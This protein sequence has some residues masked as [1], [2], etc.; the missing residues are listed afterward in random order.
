MLIRVHFDALLQ[1]SQSKQQLG[2]DLM[3]EQTLLAI[4]AAVKSIL[5]HLAIPNH[6]RDVQITHLRE[7]N[8]LFDEVPHPLALEVD[9]LEPIVNL[10]FAVR[11]LV[12]SALVTAWAR[13]VYHIYIKSIL[14]FCDCV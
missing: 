6:H 10:F 1:I 5:F 8:G 2:G 7:F 4:T 3:G 11:L 13:V 12:Q 14:L 9:A